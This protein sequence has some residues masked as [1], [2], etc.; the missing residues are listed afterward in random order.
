MR[1]VL[2]SDSVAVDT[3]QAAVQEPFQEVAA[4]TEPA[5]NKHSPRHIE[6]VSTADSRKLY[7]NS[8]ENCRTLSTY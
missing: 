7:N 5:A 6:K 1:A 2:L 4:L 8:L 3:P